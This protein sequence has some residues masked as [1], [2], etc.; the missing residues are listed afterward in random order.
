MVETTQY[1]LYTHWFSGSKLGLIIAI[2][3]AWISV[4]SVCARLAA[5]PMSRVNG[6]YGWALWLPVLFTVTSWL[7]VAGYFIF[8]RKFLP[9]EYR[10][11][12]G[13]RMREMKGWNGVKHAI[14]GV[15]RL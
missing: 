5:V 14:K 1:K 12:N 13:A 11:N 6:W 9:E 8:E 10:P 3:L 2:D 4:T 15:T 7:C